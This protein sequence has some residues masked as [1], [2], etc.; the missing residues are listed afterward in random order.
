MRVPIRSAILGLERSE[1]TPKSAIPQHFEPICSAVDPARFVATLDVSHRLSDPGGLREVSGASPAPIPT[2][3]LQLQP[4]FSIAISFKRVPFVSSHSRIPAISVTSSNPAPNASATNAASLSRRALILRDSLTFFTLTLITVALFT[5]TLFLFRSFAQH[6]SEL[7]TRWSERGRA[8]LAAGHADDAVQ[9]LRTALSYNPGERSYELLLAQ[10]LAEAGHR[11]EAFNYFSG[12]WDT[13]PG[14]GFINLQL[15][16]LS[17]ARNEPQQAINFYHASIY[18]TWEGDG[19]ARRRD[20]RLELARYL[21]QQ[22]DMDPARVELLVAEGNAGDNLPLDLELAGMFLTAGD[23]ADALEADRRAVKI[24]PHNPAASAS[25]GRLAYHLGQFST[26]LPLLE[27]ALRDEKSSHPESQPGPDLS[28]IPDL[29]RNAGRILSMIPSEGL[30][31]RERVDRLLNLKQLGNQRLL[32]CAAMPNGNPPPMQDIAARWNAT[33]KSVTRSA[34]LHDPSRQD[35]LLQLIFQIE[36]LAQGTCG[37]ATG[38]D[39]LLALV[40]R[41][42]KAVTR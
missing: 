8:S 39:A 6:R 33:E 36:R 35:D 19:I 3:A 7:A 26:A 12:L 38:D 29:A 22:G 23:T 9:S 24:D 21:L 32:A 42:P 13:E 10:A 5:A 1:L 11:D 2:A 31:P 30:P 17:V 4:P 34:L 16:R 41:D 18:G 27:Q 15:A 20:V 25:A 37:T 40:S 28:D 14:N